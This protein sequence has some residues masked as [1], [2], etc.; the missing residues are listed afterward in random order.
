M[1]TMLKLAVVL[2]VVVASASQAT[3]ARQASPGIGPNFSSIGALSFGPGGVL[4][5]ADN[6]AATLFAI[7]LGALAS[8]TAPGTR[9]VPALD[10]KIA[11][12]VG[13]T[14]ASVAITDLAVHP[15]SKNTFVAIRRGE[16]TSAQPALARITAPA[17]SSS[18]RS[19][20]EI[21]S[22]TWNPAAVT[23]DEGG[24]RR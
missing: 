2:T 11:D 15:A 14:P 17:R 10:Q 20:R 19:R 16:G 1:R 23:P 6:Q 5:A 24:R 8:G 18:C 9:D 21:H 4:F 7:D 3:T 22:M 12:L 13:T